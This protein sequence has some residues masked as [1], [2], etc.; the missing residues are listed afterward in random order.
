MLETQDLPSLQ[1]RRKDLRLTLFYKI[2]YGLVPA[3]PPD[4]YLT[5]AANKRRV[6]AKRFQGFTTMNLVE[7]HQQCNSQCYTVPPA[8]KEPYKNSFFVK[9]TQEWNS[10]DDSIVSAPSV[11]SFKAR[12]TLA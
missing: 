9:T 4:Q 1:Q 6:K 5:K 7:Q 10:L 2:H 11:E 8:T 3:I 12:L